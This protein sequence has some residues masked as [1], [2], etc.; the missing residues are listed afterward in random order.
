MMSV[1]LTLS[2]LA[3]IALYPVNQTEAY[4]GN[5]IRMMYQYNS[6]SN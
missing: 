2:I 5:L 4:Y 1:E 6:M 3:A